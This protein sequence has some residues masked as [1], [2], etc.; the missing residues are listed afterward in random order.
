MELK[1]PVM[2]YDGDCEFC[3]R[4]IVRWAK[5]TGDLVG[6]QPYQDGLKEFPELS[7]GDCERAVQLVDVDGRVYSGAEAVLKTLT[8]GRY[9]GWLYWLYQKS[10]LFARMVE[11]LYRWVARH[12]G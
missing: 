5:I 3:R 11:G 4:W 7:E 12:R 9:W 1:R 2:I 8:Y 6:Y 10:G